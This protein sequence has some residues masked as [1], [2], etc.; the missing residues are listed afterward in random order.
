MNATG[1]PGRLKKEWQE[2]VEETAAM[3]YG[4]SNATGAPE[5]N[6]ERT[7]PASLQRK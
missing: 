3:I 4:P 6:D 1:G 5:H 7:S 2:V